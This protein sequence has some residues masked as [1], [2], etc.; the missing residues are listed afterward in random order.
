MTVEAA[1]PFEATDVRL[2]V[3]G[4][5]IL[6]LDACAVSASALRGIKGSARTARKS[7]AQISIQKPVS[8]KIVSPSSATSFNSAGLTTLLT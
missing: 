6:E 4:A 7:G 3:D 8:T 1:T 2:P 5:E